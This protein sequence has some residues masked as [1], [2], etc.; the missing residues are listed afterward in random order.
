M[1][2]AGRR[3]P[4]TSPVPNSEQASRGFTFVEVLVA[5]L[6]AGLLVMAAGRAMLTVLRAEQIHSA[7]Q[8]SR[9]LAMMLTAENGLHSSTTN[10]LAHQMP[11]GW[12]LAEQRITT[13]EDTNAIT[14]QCYTVTTEISPGF[15]LVVACRSIAEADAQPEP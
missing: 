10:R 3:K 7:M 5:L 1:N 2:R 8:T 14:W 4:V 6:V 13:G 12:T 15:G 9:H 11:A